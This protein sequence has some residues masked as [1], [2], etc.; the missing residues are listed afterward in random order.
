MGWD[1]V[2]MI[3]FDMYGM[4]MLTW[5]MFTSHDVR[6]TPIPRVNYNANEI[7]TWGEVYNK[8][9]PLLTKHACQEHVRLLPLLVDNC[10]YRPDNIPQLQDISEFLKG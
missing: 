2:V 5:H 4:L 9:T 1:V 7:A 6:G 3:V 8:L 10:G